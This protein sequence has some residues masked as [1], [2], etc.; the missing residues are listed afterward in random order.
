MRI[1]LCMYMHVKHCG[2]TFAP[3]C[4]RSDRLSEDFQKIYG[5]SSTF[6]IIFNNITPFPFNYNNALNYASHAVMSTI[7][8]WFVIVCKRCLSF[9]E[10]DHFVSLQEFEREAIKRYLVNKRL[11]TPLYYSTWLLILQCRFLLYT[12]LFCIR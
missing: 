6:S 12:N 5:S 2:A 10:K 3:P 9:E 4:G 7:S 11:S 1:L 8:L